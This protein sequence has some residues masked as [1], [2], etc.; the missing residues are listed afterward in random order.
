MHDSLQGLTKHMTVD[1]A[2]MQKSLAKT[3]AA[4]EPKWNTEGWDAPEW[5]QVNIVNNYP[6]AK[7]ES[8]ERDEVA[9]GIRLAATL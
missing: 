7:P 2:P 6:V 9:S 4:L 1:T 5:K 8:A 3:T